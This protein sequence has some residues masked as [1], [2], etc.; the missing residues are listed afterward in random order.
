MSET[1]P[2]Q[3][4]ERPPLLVIVPGLKGSHLRTTASRRCCCRRVYANLWRL[5]SGKCCGCGDQMRLPREYDAEGRQLHDELVADGIVADIRCCC[6][7]VKVTEMYAPLLTIGETHTGQDVVSFPYDW[8]R[9]PAEAST[10]LEAFIDA[11]LASRGGD[12]R[13]AQ[14]VAHSNGAVVAWPLVNRR[15]EL[16]HSLL[17]IAPAFSG[18][19][20]FLP[21]ISRAGDAGNKLAFNSTMMTPEHWMGWPTPF[22]FFPEAHQKMTGGRPP[23]MEADGTTAVEVDMHEFQHWKDY[24]LGPYHPDSGVTMSPEEELFLHQTL[25]KAKAYRQLI[26]HDP[27]VQYPPI[28]VLTS[29]CSDRTVTTWRRPTP[30]A[31][32]HQITHAGAVHAFQHG[33]SACRGHLLTR[34]VPQ[35]RRSCSTRQTLR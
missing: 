34:S 32:T 14:V 18:A 24:Q 19:V 25:V 17:L 13:G 22:Y 33:A 6:G 31:R 20:S 7:C 27:L 8:R 23:F 12:P 16:F 35:T 9:S 4:S 30:G 21:D 2:I 5:L 26:C 28:G 1:Q 29:T 10:Q 3:K 11:E 15:S